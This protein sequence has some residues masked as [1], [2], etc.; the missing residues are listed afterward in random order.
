MIKLKPY[1]D[2]LE[3]INFILDT[4]QYNFINH[5]INRL[6]INMAL[7]SN[8]YEFIESLHLIYIF[9]LAIISK[10]DLDAHQ[11]FFPVVKTFLY[12][13]YKTSS[14]YIDLLNFYIKSDNSEKKIKNIQL[15]T[16][17]NF[18]LEY[19]KKFSEIF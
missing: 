17:I 18:I 4:G 10:F 12:E 5:K 15:L 9:A 19:K 2:E 7:S 1:N 13:C 16:I 6:K 3:Y 11:T 14:Y 8:D